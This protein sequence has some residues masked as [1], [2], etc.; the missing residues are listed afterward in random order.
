MTL[1]EE[2][3]M[4]GFIFVLLFIIIALATLLIGVFLKAQR[5]VDAAI[6]VYTATYWR[7][8]TPRLS[9]HSEAELW[10]QL[11]DELGLEPGTATALGVGD[12]N[13]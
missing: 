6:Q 8:S 9:E 4:T 2:T 10:K 1:A 11:R 13:A 7:S 3:N 5:I 12:P